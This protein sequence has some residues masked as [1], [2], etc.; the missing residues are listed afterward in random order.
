LAL[1]YDFHL[2]L[3]GIDRNIIAVR[4]DYPPVRNLVVRVNDVVA[5]L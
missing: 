4:T 3:N 2:V 5:E 1:S